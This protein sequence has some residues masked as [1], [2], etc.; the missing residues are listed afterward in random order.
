MSKLFR[1]LT[2]ALLASTTVGC[3]MVSDIL[4]NSDK[5]HS[6]RR[7]KDDDDDKPTKKKKKK[8]KKV[9]SAKKDQAVLADVGFRP[10]K[11]GFGFRNT[12]GKYPM[13][14]PVLNE[15]V[16]VK[17]FGPEACIGGDT[18]NCSL[19]LPAFEWANMINR[20]MNGGQCEGMAVAS[21]TY[22][23]KLDKPNSP[24]PL[25]THEVSR[26]EAT[27]LI[28]YYW[29]YQALD[30]VMSATVRARRAST[31]VEV[32]DEL[33]KMLNKG[34]LATIAF[35]NPRGRGGHAVTPYA[36]EDKGNDVHWI[37]IY[38]N[39]YPDTER[40]II[41]DRKANTWRYDLAALNPSVPKMPWD[42][43]P[44]SHNI[45]VLPLDLRLQRAAC[46][47]CEASEQRVIWP[48][49]ASVSVADQ[50][51]NTLSV[52]NG[53]IKNN[54]PGAEVVDLSAWT[55][56]SES[57]DPIYFLPAKNDYDITI[58]KGA[59]SASAP[60]DE[61]GVAV[62]GAGAAVT[63]EGVDMNDGDKDTLTLAH[64]AD[65]VRYRSASGK[66]PALKLA[67]ADSKDGVSVRVANLK[68]DAD[69]EVELSF[70]RKAGKAILQGGGKSTESYDLELRHVGG[71]RK[72]VDK[73]V[74]KGVRFKLGESHSIEMARPAVIKPGVAAAPKI[75]RGV[76]VA[77]PKVVAKDKDKDAA[78]PDASNRPDPSRITG[79]K[80]AAKDKADPPRIKPGTNTAPPKPTGAPVLKKGLTI[81]KP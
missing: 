79:P 39:N 15:K 73:V 37:K 4:K 7:D 2:V 70:D 44:D 17:L 40:Y 75:S 32:E 26:E 8:K 51:G 47:F 81:K 9:A 13:T 23:K 69:S 58:Q 14:D 12:G 10:E 72:G 71:G 57:V 66:M 61:K 6:S 46:P 41:I 27:P 1:L 18:E 54:I 52:E 48:R 49:S 43:G 16:M 45:V 29:S 74:Q 22:F 55:D 76:F 34:E 33:I 56:G 25:L 28:A 65:G 68:A 36:I 30:P 38:D 64:G 53:E 11:D 78:R 63:V 24:M 31:P 59:A 42:G 20:A 67:L 21:L 62:F 5:K 35:W 19:T 77:R 80:D 3:D 60:D 50:D